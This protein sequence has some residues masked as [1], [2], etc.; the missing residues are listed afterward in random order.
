[1]PAK[2]TVDVRRDPSPRLMKPD[3]VRPQGADQYRLP[4]G[5]D[6]KNKPGEHSC[7]GDICPGC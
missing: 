4:A 3:V 1:M 2:P 7:V 5:Y 6:D